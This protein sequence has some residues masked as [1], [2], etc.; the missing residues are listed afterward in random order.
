MSLKK[1]RDATIQRLYEMLNLGTLPDVPFSNEV[2]LNLTN[3]I[4]L[5]LEDCRKDLEDQR[6]KIFSL[7][8]S[9]DVLIVLWYFVQ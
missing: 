6:V 3:C 2:A 4:E 9:S 5:R 7:L 8:F 1:E